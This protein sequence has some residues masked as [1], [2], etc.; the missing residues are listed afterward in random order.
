MHA[1]ETAHEEVLRLRGTSHLA[2]G[3]VAFVQIVALVMAYDVWAD[4]TG[5]RAHLPM[6]DGFLAHSPDASHP[7]SRRVDRCTFDVQAR[8]H[9]SGQA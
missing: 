1:A 3:S 6:N 5:S 9:D 7:G 4:P 8:K 2:H